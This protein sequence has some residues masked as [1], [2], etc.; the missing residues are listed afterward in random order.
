M[1]SL[2]FLMDHRRIRSLIP[3][4]SRWGG[5]PFLRFWSKH[6]IEVEKRIDT[7]TAEFVYMGMAK[8]STVSHR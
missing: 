5:R 2:G 4:D 1:R 7:E 3:T 6:V 8:H